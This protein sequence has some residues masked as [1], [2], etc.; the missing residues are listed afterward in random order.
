MSFETAAILAKAGIPVAIQSGFEQYVPRAR[1]LLFEAGAAVANG[2][3]PEQALAAITTTPAKIIGLDKRVGSLEKGKD[4]DL[5]LYDGDPFEY[6]SHVCAVII[7][8]K[9]VSE[10]CN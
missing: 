6:T 1:V 8:G 9:V 10:E 7:D 4:A 5:V 2:M 3:T